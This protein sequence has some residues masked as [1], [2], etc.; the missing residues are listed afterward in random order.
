MDVN[1]TPLAS[2]AQDIAPDE[3]AR[4]FRW[5]RR[6]GNPAW[7][8]PHISPPRWREAL[9]RI[10]GVVRALLPSSSTA[11]ALEGEAAA[12]GLAGYTS[13][14]GPLLG[15]WV[16]Q[17]RLSCPAP[18]AAVLELHLRHNR[19]RAARMEA[20]AVAVV[21][22]LLE[23]DIAVAVLKGAHTARAYF[24]DP[25]ARP[26]SDVDLLVA[27]GDA[28]RA[29]AVLQSAG[30]V[31][32]SRGPRESGWKPAAAPSAPRSLMLAHADDP[33]SVDLHSSLNVMVSPG[34]PLADL[35]AGA[36]LSGRERWAPCPGAV[37]LDQPLLL[38]HLAVHAGSGFQNLTL[39]RLTE[40]NL[41]IGRDAASGDLSWDAFLDLGAR[42]GS[43]GF[44]YPALRLSEALTPG[45]V[46]PPVLERCARS[47]PP[48]VRRVLEGMTPASAQRID[49]ASV[50]EHFM[51]ARGWSGRLRQIAFD[52]AP[53]GGSWREVWSIYETRAWRLARGAFSR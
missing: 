43:L 30:F 28:R 40:L 10:E 42:T 1:F 8:W 15:W 51:W 48:G 31:A 12:I 22:A 38:L 7:L 20:G 18:L 37:V 17:G 44:A 33:W 27:G 35:D 14:L 13:G 45:L 25:G 50:A 39:L 32:K 24:P 34:A 29:E 4:R 36:P 26:A 16:E 2:D 52:L 11:A 9:E 41:V 19:L 23:R 3:I 49:R 21:G 6:Q 47:A 46:P 5:A 53:P